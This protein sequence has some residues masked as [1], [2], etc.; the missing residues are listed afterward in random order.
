LRNGVFFTHYPLLNKV[1]IAALVIYITALV[2]KFF[3]NSKLLSLDHADIFS[4][5]F[6]FGG[7]F[8]LNQQIITGL[9]IWPFHFVQYTIPLSIIAVF[10]ILHRVI[11][12]H[13]RVVW[14]GSIGIIVVA[15][16]WLGVYTQYKTYVN[17]LDHNKEVQ[18]YAPVFDWFNQQ[19]K[20]QNKFTDCQSGD[21]RNP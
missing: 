12:E 5:A 6:L 14:V 21:K 9:T 10:V 19:E 3:K 13:W 2:F 20:W 8:A 4:L 15:S 7:L 17:F 18:L 1:L 11:R 16:M